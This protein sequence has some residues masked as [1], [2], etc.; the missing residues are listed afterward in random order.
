MAVTL[1]RVD[2][3]WTSQSGIPTPGYD[4][5]RAR[6]ARASIHFFFDLLV[7]L[8][9]L[10]R[11]GIASLTFPSIMDTISLS[12][13]AFKSAFSLQSAPF[14]VNT[15]LSMVCS[16]ESRRLRGRL[17][18]RQPASQHVRAQSATASLFV[19]CEGCFGP[20]A[21]VITHALSW[22]F[23]SQHGALIAMCACGLDLGS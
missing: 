3:G 2:N 16:P 9:V 7:L 8:I 23:V 1:H 22:A 6:P 15:V 5:P 19:P 10:L 12:V 14:Q 18:L 17:R 20:D 21:V 4:V 11:P 13:T